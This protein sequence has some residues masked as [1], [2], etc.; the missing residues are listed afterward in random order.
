MSGTKYQR[1][2]YVACPNKS[3]R[4]IAGFVARWIIPADE[5]TGSVAA[6]DPA[7]RCF[8][9]SAQHACS[10]PIFLSHRFASL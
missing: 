4:V 9:P 7:R 1:G 8:P 6:I 10:V 2:E 3:S 5:M